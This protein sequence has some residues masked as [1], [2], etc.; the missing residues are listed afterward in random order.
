L[1]LEHLEDTFYKT[2]LAKFTESDFTDAGFAP[3]VRGRFVQIGQH[4]AEHVAFLTSALGSEATSACNYSFPVTDAA[5]FVALSGILEGVGSSAYLGAAQFISDPA[6]LTAA[7]SILVTEGRH[8]GWVQAAVE[9][10]APWSSAFETPQTFDEVFSLASP[11]IT[12]CPST[13]PALPFVAFPN[14]TVTPATPAAGDNITLAF[15]GNSTGAFLA[16]L[17]GLNQTF[18]PI[19]NNSAILPAGLQGTVYAVV[20]NSSSAVADNNTIAGPAIL[21]FPFDSS[22]SNP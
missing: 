11:F 7:G 10:E 17:H 16:L 22:A 20:S 8:Q 1:T 3:W 12:S 14:L 4:E 9:K 6:V 13:N 2:Y 21:Q 5:S 15:S 18:V 19:S